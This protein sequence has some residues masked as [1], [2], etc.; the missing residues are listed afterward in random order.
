MF[1]G[2]FV[3]QNVILDVSQVA[4]KVVKNHLMARQLL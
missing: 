2:K 1:G 3:G 4:Q